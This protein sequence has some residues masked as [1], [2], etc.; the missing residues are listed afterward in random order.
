MLPTTASKSRAP[1]A[2]QQD[3]SVERA[4]AAIKKI[5]VKRTPLEMLFSLQE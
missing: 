2:L 5:P 1:K 4:R 3:A